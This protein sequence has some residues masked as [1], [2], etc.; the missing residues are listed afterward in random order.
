MKSRLAL[1]GVAL[2]PRVGGIDGQLVVYYRL[3]RLVPPDS[4]R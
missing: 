1:L 2:L 4:R 3:S